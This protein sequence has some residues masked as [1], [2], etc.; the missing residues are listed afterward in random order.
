MNT[1]HSLA[2]IALA[3]GCS[4]K[5][6]PKIQNLQKNVEHIS[7]QM[8]Q[9][10]S[11][12]ADLR[13]LVTAY[14]TVLPLTT[15]GLS[16]EGE[17]VSIGVVR[18]TSGTQSFTLPETLP[19]N[20][21]MVRINAFH[22]SGAEGPSR[23]VLYRLWTEVG[24]EQHVHFLY[25]WRFPQSAISFQAPEFWFPVDTN[26]WAVKAS[27]ESRQPSNDHAVHLYVSGYKL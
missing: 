2:A 17:P 10:Q 1:A 14:S 13:G 19:S 11:E 21:S 27:T 23:Q 22:R 5:Q 26:N 3:Y 6:N 4:S 15:A 12:L 25:G 18:S 8:T 16:W 7:V 24:G 20:A 9:L